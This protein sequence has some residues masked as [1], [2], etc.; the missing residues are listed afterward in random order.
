MSHPVGLTTSCMYLEYRQVHLDLA[1]WIVQRIQNSVIL[2]NCDIH[3]SCIAIRAGRGK[4]RSFSSTQQLIKSGH[5]SCVDGVTASIQPMHLVV[6]IRSHGYPEYAMQSMKDYRVR[7]IH[8]RGYLLSS[9]QDRVDC[10]T[11]KETPKN[12][13]SYCKTLT[14]SILPACCGWLDLELH[15]TNWFKVWR[16][17]P[18]SLL[19][20]QH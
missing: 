5:V 1:K 3:C 13:V 6:G 17:V 15:Q 4:N 10:C 12:H 7:Y 19:P 20:M 16:N 9:S 8:T 11:E 18:R 14:V 2:K